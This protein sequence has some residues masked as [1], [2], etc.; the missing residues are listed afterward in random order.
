MPKTSKATKIQP[1]IAK[2]RGAFCRVGLMP[3]EARACIGRDDTFVMK[4]AGRMMVGT[5]HND[6]GQILPVL[7][8]RVDWTNARFQ[9][10]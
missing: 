7:A 6:D 1:M 2:F 10:L 9:S 3:T 5:V 8:D 4:I